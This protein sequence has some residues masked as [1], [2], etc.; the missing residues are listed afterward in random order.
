MYT[1]VFMWTPALSPP[2]S[3]A[4]SP[5]LNHLC[6]LYGHEHGWQLHQR[7]AG[8]AR[9]PSRVLGTV[10]VGAAALSLPCFF[11]GS[12]ALLSFASSVYFPTTVKSRVVPE[13]A[14]AAAAVYRVPLNVIVLGV[15]LTDMSQKVAFACC[16]AML[17]AGTILA[18]V[19]HR[20]ASCGR[21]RSAAHAGLGALVAGEGAGDD[22]DG[23]YA[24]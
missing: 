12:V 21:A 1:F 9:K 3:R 17:A 24:V 6:H 2:D 8:A 11:G 10:A 14:R 20:A 15:L 16:V 13:D 19:L 5:P 18:V 22:S 7:A 23:D 4:A